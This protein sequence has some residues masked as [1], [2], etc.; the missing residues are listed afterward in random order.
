[1]GNIIV[2]I[3]VYNKN[4]IKQYFGKKEECMDGDGSK[5]IDRNFAILFN[6]LSSSLIII[7]SEEQIKSLELLYIQNF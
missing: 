2:M 5:I 3:D 6:I 7:W 4:F 1:M